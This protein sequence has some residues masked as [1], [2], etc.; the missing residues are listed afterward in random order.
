MRPSTAHGHCKS[1]TRIVSASGVAFPEPRLE[2]WGPDTH[3]RDCRSQFRTM[4]PEFLSILYFFIQWCRMA[5]DA[6]S[7]EVGCL[8][9][10]IPLMT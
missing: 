7:K 10:M 1:L 4:S 6:R 3:S 9:A 8:K 5:V 2:F